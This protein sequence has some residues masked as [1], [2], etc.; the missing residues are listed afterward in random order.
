MNLKFNHE[1]FRFVGLLDSGK[2][3]RSL[4]GIGSIILDDY[5]DICRRFNYEKTIS[6]ILNRKHISEK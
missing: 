5:N 6:K 3:Y 2:W 1:N 4:A